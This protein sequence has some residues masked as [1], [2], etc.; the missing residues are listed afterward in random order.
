MQRNVDPL[1]SVRISRRRRAAWTIP[2]I[3]AL[4]ACG[5]GAIEEDSAST[6]AASQE[7]ADA[8]DVGDVRSDVSSVGS[9]PDMLVESLDTVVEGSARASKSAVTATTTTTVAI[10]APVNQSPFGVASSTSS[11]R[12]LSSWVPLVAQAGVQSVRGFD[13]NSNFRGIDPTLAAGMTVSS[14]YNYHAITDIPAWTSYITRMT[15]TFKGRVQEW[16]VW[17]EPPNFT[18]NTPPQEYGAMVAHAY[19]AAKAVD[20]NVKVGLAAQSVNL[21]YLDQALVAGAAGHF[22]FVT[23][24][25]YETADL[26]SRGF[27]AQYMSI[28]PNIRK[29]LAARSPAQANVPVIFTEVG[30]PVDAGTTPEMQGDLLVKLYTMGIAQGAQRI[31]WFEPL[32]GDSGPFGLI[33]PKGQPRPSYKALTSL[34]KYLGERPRY[35][36]WVLLKNKHYGFLFHG[37][38]GMVLVTW[39]PPG[40]SQW[41]DLGRKMTVVFPRSDTSRIGTSI[42]LRNAP[43]L[44]LPGA[45]VPGWAAAARANLHKPFPWGG[46]YSQAKGISLTGG[47]HPVQTFAARTIDG[48][49]VHDAGTVARHSF[50]VDPNFLSY[51]PSRIRITAVVR[52]NSEKSAGFN[53]KYESTSGWR[54]KPGWNSVPSSTKWT[55]LSWVITDPQF[56]GKW[57]YNFTFDSDSTTNSGYSI[58]SLTVTKE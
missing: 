33:D 38:R 22:D 5:G 28:V 16:E 7:S 25:P 37:P 46:D 31:H 45:D 21:N 14:I 30:K 48:E 9:T 57:G 20:R 47:L 3:A 49:R 55:T 50:T 39:A 11:S 56:V 29:M 32:D 15:N 27:E 13:K 52:R 42:T 54:S 23:V 40:V 58:R 43:V 26:V 34:I 6:A 24:H 36:G 41:I 19:P 1:R 35:Y 51:T 44:I 2:V 18:P 10:P 12:S 8:A 17:N 53:V 4:S